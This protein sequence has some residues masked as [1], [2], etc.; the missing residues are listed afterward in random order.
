LVHRRIVTSMTLWA[1]NFKLGY[2]IHSSC[3]SKERFS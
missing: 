1:T 3:A 2:V